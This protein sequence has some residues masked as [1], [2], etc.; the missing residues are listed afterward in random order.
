MATKLGVNATKIAANPAQLAE[1]GDQAGRIRCMYDEYTF[2]A[3]LASNDVIKLGGLL[4]AGSRVLDV[5]FGFDDLDTTGGTIDVGWAA[6]AD[7]AVSADDDGFLANVDVTSAGLVTMQDDQASVPGLFK[8]F[9]SPVQIQA[10]IDGDTDV[11]TGSVKIAVY[12]VID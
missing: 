10:K 5:V 12:Y 7:A 4:P 2:T 11:T 9:A 1:Q 6:S 3:D 8:R